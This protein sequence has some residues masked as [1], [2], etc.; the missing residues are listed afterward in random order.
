MSAAERAL[1]ARTRSGGG[2]N[3]LSSTREQ[4]QR[5]EAECFATVLL[6]K[7]EGCSEVVDETVQEAHLTVGVFRLCQEWD[8]GGTLHHFSMATT[9]ESRG[10]T[11]LQEEKEEEDGRVPQ[12]GDA[13]WGALWLAQVPAF[14]RVPN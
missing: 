4:Q 13:G 11:P 1:E 5:E 2:S 7:E 14:L 12:A 8:V 3:Q 6:D 10:G 9:D